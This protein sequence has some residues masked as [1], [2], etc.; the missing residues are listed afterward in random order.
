VIPRSRAFVGLG[1]NLGDRRSMLETAL[2]GLAAL[3]GTSLAAVS[4]ALM[5]FI[6]TMPASTAAFMKASRWSLAKVLPRH[7]ETCRARRLLPQKIRNTGALAT[8]GL[9]GT[10]AAIFARSCAS[11]TCTMSACC[12]SLFDGADIAVANSSCSNS[13]ATARAE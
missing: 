10:S 1:S 5:K 9:S 2:G 7:S 11:H 8:H 12:K 13:G 6:S 4:A 3:E